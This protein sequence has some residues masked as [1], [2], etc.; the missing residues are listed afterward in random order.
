MC[1]GSECLALSVVATQAPPHGGATETGAWRRHMRHSLPIDRQKW[2]EL[3]TNSKVKQENSTTY[4]CVWL[5]LP[6]EIL[7][8]HAAGW[9]IVHD[10]VRQLE[11]VLHG[12]NYRSG[13]RWF[14]YIEFLRHVQLAVWEILNTRCKRETPLPSPPPSF[15]HCIPL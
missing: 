9:L 12:G 6:L 5:K 10:S 11:N 15:P 8:Q 13:A 4:K 7:V 3:N 2:H 14:V 1:L